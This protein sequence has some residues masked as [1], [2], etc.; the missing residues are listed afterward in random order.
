[1]GCHSLTDPILIWY[2]N[3]DIKQ[4]SYFMKNNIFFLCFLGLLVSVTAELDCVAAGIPNAEKEVLYVTHEPGH[5]HDYTSQKELFLK[6]SK[7]AG[8]K[9]SVITGTHK[10]EPD[11][12]PLEEDMASKLM[13]RNYA[14]GYDAVV[15]NFCLALSKDLELCENIIAQTRD[16]GV[17]AL[18]IHCSLHSFWPTYRDGPIGSLGSEYKGQAQP[19]AELVS[20]WRMNHPGKAF[21]AW[22]DFTGLASAVHGPSTQPIKCVKL[23]DNHPAVERMTDGFITGGTE[24]YNN[25]YQSDDVI[26]LIL[27]IQYI[28]NSQIATAVILWEAPVGNSKLLAFTLGHNLDDWTLEDFRVILIDSVNYL[29]ESKS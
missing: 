11:M 8:W 20:E 19:E 25:F 17:P 13:E 4:L 26:P 7:E 12:P 24:L 1:M 22:G 21:P 28:E 9:T 14:E 3:S 6:Y 5:W 15:Y 2:K 23:F 27:G 16:L 18:L 10:W 29:I